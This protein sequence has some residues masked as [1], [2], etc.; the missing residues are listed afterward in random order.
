MSD[1]E[2]PFVSCSCM[3]KVSFWLLDCLYVVASEITP[4]DIY[5]RV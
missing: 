3:L 2:L 1:V 5:A 4:D